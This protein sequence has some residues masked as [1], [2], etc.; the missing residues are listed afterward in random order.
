[1]YDSMVQTIQ[2]HANEILSKN[3]T[4]CEA[5]EF[6]NCYMYIFTNK[7]KWILT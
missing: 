6:F 4:G 5:T 3:Y 2:I 1:M 7:Q